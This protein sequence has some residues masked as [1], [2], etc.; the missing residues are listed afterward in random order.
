MTKVVFHQAFDFA[1]VDLAE[2]LGG[3]VI[4][5]QYAQAV[6]PEKVRVALNESGL[7]DVTVQNFGTT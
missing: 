6:E 2:F 4:Q 1:N 5:V 3:T 7:T